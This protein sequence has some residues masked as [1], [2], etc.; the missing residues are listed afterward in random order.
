MNY[1][2]VRDLAALE[3][4]TLAPGLADVPVGADDRQLR[5]RG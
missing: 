1:H 2:T 4:A 5:Q 3:Q